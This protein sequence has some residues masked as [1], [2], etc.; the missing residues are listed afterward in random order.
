M[1]KDKND[2]LLCFGL[3]D[4]LGILSLKEKQKTHSLQSSG[5]GYRSAWTSG[6]QGFL[7]KVKGFRSWLQQLGYSAMN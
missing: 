5:S 6:L 3:N 1:A 2:Q 7:I 4:R